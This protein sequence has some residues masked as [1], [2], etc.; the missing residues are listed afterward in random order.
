[1]DSDCHLRRLPSRAR[2]RVSVC[3]RPARTCINSFSVEIGMRCASTRSG[4]GDSSIGIWACR[5]SKSI[6]RCNVPYTDWPADLLDLWQCQGWICGCVKG[7]DCAGMAQGDQEW[8]CDMLTP[9]QTRGHREYQHHLQG[10]SKC[11]IHAAQKMSGWWI[12]VWWQLHHPLWCSMHNTRQLMGSKCQSQHVVSNH[13]N[14]PYEPAPKISPSLNLPS[15]RMGTL[16]IVYSTI[17][18]K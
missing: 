5:T 6:G 4:C 11:C 17:A 15:T 10:V 2:L 12:Q 8:E 3:S 9:Y 16:S 1:M 7:R 13:D 14:T 18:H